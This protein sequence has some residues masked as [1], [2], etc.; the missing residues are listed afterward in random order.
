M[1]ELPATYIHQEQEC[2]ICLVSC[3]KPVK[4]KGP[5]QKP[6]CLKCAAQAKCSDDRC[7][8]RCSKPFEVDTIKIP[9]RCPYR[10]EE[11]VMSI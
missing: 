2:S 1:D 9:L 11:C 7:P 8:H 6:F 4:C 10:P 5:C 3:I